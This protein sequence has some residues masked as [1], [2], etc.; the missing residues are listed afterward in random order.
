MFT[1]L[2][3]EVRSLAPRSDDITQLVRDCKLW[4]VGYQRVVCHISQPSYD[5]N[6]WLYNCL[7]WHSDHL[8]RQEYCVVRS[9][10]NV[11]F[12]NWLAGH[13]WE[14]KGNAGVACCMDRR[15]NEQQIW[16][17]LYSIS[18]Q[19]GLIITIL[20]KIW[21]GM[22]RKTGDSQ[23]FKLQVKLRSDILKTRLLWQLLG[24]RRVQ[25]YTHHI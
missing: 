8:I 14:H 12:W 17:M 19:T 10:H 18:K 20:S 1:F 25:L 23:R 21:Q 11:V 9:W 15:E 4:F 2:F 5:K 24:N 22:K 7:I 6:L 13:P 16:L 3:P